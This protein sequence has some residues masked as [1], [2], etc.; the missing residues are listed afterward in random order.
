MGF[1]RLP[2]LLEKLLVSVLR[3]KGQ[4]PEVDYPINP[5][6]GFLIYT[7]RAFNLAVYHARVGQRVVIC[8][9]DSVNQNLIRLFQSISQLGLINLH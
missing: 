8:D 3:N 7:I 2:Y 1:L 4:F 5:A 6:P 9:G